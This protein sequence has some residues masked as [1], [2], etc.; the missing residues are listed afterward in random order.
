MPRTVLSVSGLG[1]RYTTYRSELR[2]FASWFGAGVNPSAEYWA[3]RDVHLS[4]GKGESVA[5]IGENGAGKSTLLKLI[6]G[7]VRPTEGTVVKHGR[8]SA[9]LELGLGLNP[10]FTGRQNVLGAGLMLGYSPSEIEALVPGIADFAELGDFFDQPL[11]QYSSGMYARLA[12]AL[13]TATRPDILI[14]DEIL[15][16][17]DAYFQHK[18]FARIREYREQG[19]SI[20][21]VSHSKSSVLE[22]CDRAVLLERGR[23]IRDG[24]P[25]AVFDYYNALI[26]DR[27]VEVSQVEGERGT[28]T[29]SGNGNAVVRTMALRNSRGICVDSIDVGEKVTLQAHIDVLA[30]LPTLVFGIMIKDRLGQEIFGSNTHHEGAVIKDA[31]AGSRYRVNVTFQNRL[32]VGSYSV[33]TALHAHDTHLGGNFEWTDLALVFTV[34]NPHHG[35]FV[36]SNWLD[37]RFG[38]SELAAGPLNQVEPGS[39]RSSASPE[40]VELR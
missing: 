37:A 13:A 25:D 15:S 4:I 30:D 3:V 9:I 22:V 7:T 39:D 33:S 32:G 14:V 40:V 5:F 28:R 19:T 11:R 36:G 34:G 29:V 1:K 2:R 24:A 23:V 6:A 8:V 21:L 10:E 27:E 35:F 18:S 17:G 26:S 31:R 12:F 16:V 20:I 38:V